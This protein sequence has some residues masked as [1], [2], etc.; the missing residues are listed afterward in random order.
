MGDRYPKDRLLLIEDHA[1]L[2]LW[3]GKALR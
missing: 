3:I 2:S 1:E